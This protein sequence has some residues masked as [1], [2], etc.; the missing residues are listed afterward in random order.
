M[1][2]VLVARNFVAAAVVVEEGT[3]QVELVLDSHPVPVQAVHTAAIVRAAVDKK[4]VEL[5]ELDNLPAAAAD[6]VAAVAEGM[7]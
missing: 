6:V 1:L 2:L 7:N 3:M 5:V 4:Q